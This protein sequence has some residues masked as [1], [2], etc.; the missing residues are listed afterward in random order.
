MVYVSV[1]G[2]P[3]TEPKAGHSE[4]H[5]CHFQKFCDLVQVSEPLSVLQYS[6]QMKDSKGSALCMPLPQE[7]CEE[8][9]VLPK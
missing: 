3:R 4:S 6:L 9:A 5:Y 1:T 7:H 8:R 2:Q